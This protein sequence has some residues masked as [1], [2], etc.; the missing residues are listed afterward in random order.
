MMRYREFDVEAPEYQPMA[1]FSSDV[2]EDPAAWLSN[3]HGSYEGSGTASRAAAG[4]RG[5]SHRA[6]LVS[7]RILVARA[8]GIRTETRPG[9]NMWP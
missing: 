4:R 9:A 7:V 3:I 5:L 1:Y 8:T 2:D 6:F